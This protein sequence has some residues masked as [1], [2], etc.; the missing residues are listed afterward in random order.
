[1]SGLRVSEH[2]PGL[3]FDAAN[4]ADFHFE[5]FSRE[6]FEL[7]VEL[8]F[9]AEFKRGGERKFVQ[10][11]IGFGEIEEDVAE[12]VA[13]FFGHANRPGG[14]LAVPWLRFELWEEH[15]GVAEGSGG[16]EPF[17]AEEALDQLFGGWRR[18]VFGR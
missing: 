18:G 2:V 11:R 3:V 14:S 6:L 4:V 13:E 10:F 9:A 17:W 12:I 1:M 7:R 16:L 5:F 8:E 15:S